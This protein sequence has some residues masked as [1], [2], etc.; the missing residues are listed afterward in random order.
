MSSYLFDIVPRCRVKEILPLELF[1]A[2]D[3]AVVLPALAGEI[4]DIDGSEG[5]SRLGPIGCLEGDHL[6]GS[7][8]VGVAVQ[9]LLQQ[10]KERSKARSTNAIKMGNSLFIWNRD[11]MVSV[12]IITLPSA[13]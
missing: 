2:I 5:P 11:W 8:L 7:R 6:L 12:A 9:M 13:F 10:V 3:V 1:C 4:F